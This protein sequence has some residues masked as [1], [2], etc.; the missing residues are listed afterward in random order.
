[1][2]VVRLTPQAKRDLD[3]IWAYTAERW[4]V[5]QAEAYLRTLDASF[6]LLADHPGIG[7]KIDDIRKGYFKFPA[8]SHIV[9]FRVNKEQVEIVRVLHKS[10]DV[11]TGVREG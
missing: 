5:A 1:M 10:R 2:I 9:I 6:K 7:R 8:G 4:D 11:E 3:E